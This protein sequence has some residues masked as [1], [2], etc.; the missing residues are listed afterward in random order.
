VKT[1]ATKVISDMKNTASRGRT[2]PSQVSVVLALM[3]REQSTESDRNVNCR[4]SVNCSFS[5]FCFIDLYTFS[6]IINN[7]TTFNL[8]NTNGVIFFQFYVIHN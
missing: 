3:Q 1:T 8:T 7:M 4:L 6:V 2:A 5:T